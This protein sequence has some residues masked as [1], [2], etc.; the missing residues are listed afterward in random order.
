MKIR[1][2]RK[3]SECGVFIENERISISVLVRTDSVNSNAN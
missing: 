1:P 2:L 3:V